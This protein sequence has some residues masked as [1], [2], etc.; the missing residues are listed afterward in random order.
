MRRVR[1]GARGTQGAV[2]GT[3]ACTRG[4]HREKGYI[5]VRREPPSLTPA[6]PQKK[7]ARRPALGHRARPRTLGRLTGYGLL[8]RGILGTLLDA[9]RIAPYGEGA[10]DDSR[11]KRDHQPLCCAVC[12][13]RASG[14]CLAGPPAQKKRSPTTPPGPGVLAD[15]ACRSERYRGCIRLSV[16]A[17]STASV[18]RVGQDLASGILRRVDRH[19]QADV[20]VAQAP[21]VGRSCRCGRI[22][23]SD[24]S[25]FCAVSTRRGPRA[26]PS[27]SATPTRVCTLAEVLE[28]RAW[29]VAPSPRAWSGL[30]PCGGRQPH[31][32]VDNLWAS[33]CGSFPSSAG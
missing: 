23:G 27:C 9:M 7:S 11:R 12:C 31:R 4:R 32:S 26:L 6:R 19:C 25:L 5:C 14:R 18:R 24:L 15:Y 30:P 22:L 28:T 13:G 3:A 20:W 29:H 10:G 8:R 2:C 21:W 1:R 33:R 17:S 16:R